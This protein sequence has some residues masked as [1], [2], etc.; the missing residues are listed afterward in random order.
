MVLV[1]KQTYGS[2]EQNRDPRSINPD[3]YG[4]LIFNK[5]DKN[6]QRKKQSSSGVGKVGQMKVNM[7]N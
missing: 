3:A 5:G 1:Q 2:I 7:W 6:I 4:Q